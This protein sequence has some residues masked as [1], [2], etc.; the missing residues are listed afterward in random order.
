MSDP[1]ASAT[2]ANPVASVTGG[3]GVGCL[4]GR[5]ALVT[6]GLGGIGWAVAARTVAEGG[7]VL[8]TD[9]A[10]TDDGRVADELGAAGRY[11]PL[12]VRSPEAWAA[13]VG[14]AVAAFGG[15]HV[16][17]NNAGVWRPAPLADFTVADAVL[18][19]EV[20]QLGCLLGMQAV[21]EPMRAAGGGSIVNV[22]SGAALSGLPLHAVYGGTKWAVR[23]MT[24]SAALELGEY[25]IRVNAVHPGSID[26]P[27]TASVRRSGNPFGFLPVPRRGRPDEVAAAV[28]HLASDA[29]SYV[30]GSDLVVDGGLSAGPHIG[31]PVTD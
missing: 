9:T 4:A 5:V 23:G 28:V 19:F 21:I 13:A 25:G 20:N 8:V 24:K 22:A 6:G 30:T 14:A 26:T 16:L 7:R 11:A 3:P 12:D 18:C 27:M 31:R 15:L 2:G 17:V 29:S 10:A 1:G